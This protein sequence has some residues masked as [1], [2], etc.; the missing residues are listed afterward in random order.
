MEN[1]NSTI[2]TKVLVPK[3]RPN[4]LRRPRLVDFL[5]EHIERKLIL[6]SASAGY[7]KTSLLTDFAHDSE[8]PVCWY[9]MA[10]SDADPRVFLEYLVASIRQRFPGFGEQTLRQMA[11]YG[12]PSPD[13]NALI[14][15]LVNE[16]HQTI[17]QYFVLILDD[18]H[19]VEQSEAVNQALDTLLHYL[20]ENCHIILASRTLPRLTLTALVAKQQAAG[21]G[22]A[23]LRFT[24][25]EI[26]ALLEQN[27][28]IHLTPEQAEDLARESEGWIT[29]ILLTTSTLWQGLFE[30]MIR[31][32]GAEGKLFD[33]LAAEVLSQQEPAIQRF[34]L[35][36]AVLQEMSA[37]LCA[38][39]LGIGDA[40]QVLETIEQ[41]NLF[42]TRVEGQEVWYRYHHLFREFLEE[43]L[44]GEDPQRFIQ[45]H[46]KAGT[47]AEKN[48]LWYEAVHHYRRAGAFAEAARLVEQ[49]AGEM[50]RCGRWSTLVQWIE[51]LP[52]GMAAAKPALI[53]YRAKVHAD[54]GE[55]EQSIAMLNQARS[56]FAAQQNELGVAR[57]LTEKGAVCRFQGRY[58]LAIEECQQALQLLAGRDPHVAAL[59]YRIIGTGHGSQGHFTESIKLLEKALALYR[60]TGHAYNVA[61]LYHDL[62]TTYLFIGELFQARRYLQRALSY[63]QKVGNQNV[64]ANTLNCIGVV[65]TYQGEYE[66]ASL[67]LRQA[68]DKARE[69]NARRVE[70]YT[71][72][73]LGDLQR[74]QAH[75]RQALADYEEALDTAREVDEASVVLYTLNALGE[76]CRL[77]KEPARARQ[78]LAEA[79]S[80]AQEHK[81]RYESALNHFSLGALHLDEGQ[82]ESALERLSQAQA[83]FAECG[84]KR[85]LARTWFK[86]AGLSFRQRDYDAASAYLQ[87]LLD[88]VETLGYYHFL[89]VD[90][91]Q[92]LPL[93][94]HAATAHDRQL[95]GQELFA[96][97]HEEVNRSLLAAQGPDA[98]ALPASTPPSRPPPLEIQAFGPACV[99]WQG[100]LV[101]KSDWDSTV[102]KELF[103]YLL[104]HRQGRRKEQVIAEL[105]GQ[106]S[107]AKANGVFHSTAYRLRRA[108]S[109]DCLLYEDGLY[110]LDA[111]LIAWYDVAQFEG[112]ISLGGQ[113]RSREEEVEHYRQA[114][115]L[116]R[117]DYLEEFYGDWT[118]ARREELAEK[119][120]LALLRLGHLLLE[121]GDFVQALA[122]GQAVL[123]RDNCREEAYRLLMLSSAAR[124]DRA[125]AIRWYQRC[126]ATLREE[127]G[128]TPMPE[129]V[130]IYEEIVANEGGLKQIAPALTNLHSRRRER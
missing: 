94:Q 106:S 11:G 120:V 101:S 39:L 105:W 32:R 91:R 103:F 26:R 124:G 96:T 108:L 24:A 97:I 8:L 85:D 48:R 4:L 86:L 68:L 36:S 55:L 126:Q 53:L 114:I 49:L 50:Y 113:A 33:Y 9:A 116:Y 23:D 99:R 35:D 29:G 125:L 109:A 16:I 5:H 34:L 82:Y 27:H 46:G 7:G 119:Y 20:P 66:Q 19:A 10:P 60:K 123:E 92:D 58:D 42:V 18:Y 95:S 127:L 31:A 90:G 112:A 83:L 54:T 74:D 115:E 41:R 51:E 43:R 6:V 89:V 3:K 78:L 12:Q 128:V 13:I 98:L 100:E 52:E 111:D 81:A 25:E 37:P 2:I 59:A 1:P 22:V 65:H 104:A 40:C 71:L 45:L 110:R 72:A 107:P 88:L 69:C 79:L 28:N 61:S 75:Y 67:V 93:L 57:T 122:C 117:G 77:M 64:L 62:G 15:T 14:G 80:A 47:L 129:T 87:Q 63:W 121:G 38:E 17:P 130:V 73:S 118:A 84:A 76:T 102:T 30:T 70:A 21:M 44:R 56:A